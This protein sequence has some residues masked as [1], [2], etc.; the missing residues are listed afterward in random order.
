MI[1]LA[2]HAEVDSQYPTLSRLV[3]AGNDTLTAGEL[4]SQDFGATRL[5]VLSA[6]R[7]AR[8]PI[9][10]T[11]GVESLAR[12]F[13]AAGVPAVVASLWDVDDGATAELMIAFHRHLR[14]GL[15]GPAALRAA[16]IELLRSDDDGLRSAAGWGAFQWIGGWPTPAP[17]ASER[18]R[19]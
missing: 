17:L 1:H 3:L 19:S 12:P 10:A 13:L 4:Y 18:N 9:T 5:V 16:Q 6:C 8:G 14:S 11:E 15:T 2:A 7:T